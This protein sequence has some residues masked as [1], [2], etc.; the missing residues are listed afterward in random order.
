VSFPVKIL[1]KCLR[2]QSETNSDFFHR[3]G[4]TERP[5]HLPLH[6][7]TV[8]HMSEVLLLLH[9]NG[10]FTDTDGFIG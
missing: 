2:N 7:V 10:N 3:Y 4:R 6:A 5:V 9:L 1:S 8:Q